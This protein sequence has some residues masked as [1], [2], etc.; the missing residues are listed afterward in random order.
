ML[1]ALEA[2]WERSKHVSSPQGCF[3]AAWFRNINF[4]VAKSVA[5]QIL[6][7]LLRVHAQGSTLVESKASKVH[8]PSN[9]WC[10]VTTD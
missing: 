1:I 2:S 5:A 6:K 7:T 4:Q 8:L 3:S 10:C 9:K